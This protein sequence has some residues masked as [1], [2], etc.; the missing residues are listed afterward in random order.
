MPIVMLV[1]VQIVIH[2][3]F[4]FSISAATI[5]AVAVPPPSRAPAVLLPK[6]RWRP[7]LRLTSRV[8][9][10]AE[11]SLRHG[12]PWHFQS[13]FMSAS[14]GFQRLGDAPGVTGETGLK[15]RSGMLPS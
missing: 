5:L 8:F 12:A 9:Q 3:S 2:P 4:L 15:G 6:R 1:R 11:R 13:A 7:L 14:V 10:C